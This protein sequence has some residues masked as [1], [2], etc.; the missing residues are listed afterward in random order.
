MADD[1]DDMRERLN[2]LHAKAVDNF[3][4]TYL[5]CFKREDPQSAAETTAVAG[6][7]V[8]SLVTVAARIA[9]DLNMSVDVLAAMA[10]ESYEQAQRDAPKWS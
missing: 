7:L 5:G 2:A 3:F 4:V 8:G 9:L 10:R 1:L 6:A